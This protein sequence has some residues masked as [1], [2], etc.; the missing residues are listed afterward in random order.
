MVEGSFKDPFFLILDKYVLNSHTDTTSMRSREV[1]VRERVKQAATISNALHHDS[2]PRSRDRT[3]TEC[4]CIGLGSDKEASPPHCLTPPPSVESGRSNAAMDSYDPSDGPTA[5]MKSHVRRRP[6]P[7]GTAS[8][9]DALLPSHNEE[10]YPV[11]QSYMGRRRVSSY[12]TRPWYR[13]PQQLILLGILAWAGSVMYLSSLAHSILRTQKE[14]THSNMMGSSMMTNDEY[15]KRW[16]ESQGVSTS[17][18]YGA[19]ATTSDTSTINNE[20]FQKWLANQNK[21][22]ASSSSSSSDL[23]DAYQD[24]LQSLKYGASDP[25]TNNEDFKKWLAEQNK[26]GSGDKSTNEDF[27]KWLS[28]QNKYGSSSS[29]LGDAYQDYLQALKYGASDSSANEDFQKW[30][31]EQNKYGASNNDLGDAYQDW[32]QSLKYGA[33]SSIN[34]GKA[35]SVNVRFG[36]SDPS[37]QDW[38]E[39]QSKNTE[40]KYNANGMFSSDQPSL[41]RR[42]DSELSLLAPSESTSSTISTIDWPLQGISHSSCLNAN[43]CS[44][45]NNITVLIVYGPEFHSHISE[46]AWNVAIGVHTAFQSHIRHHPNSPT[47]GHIVYGHTSNITFSDVIDADAIIIGSPVYNGNVHPDVQNVSCI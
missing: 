39:Y 34:G 46:M 32:L 14:V 17:T 44:P 23:G 25:L 38:L 13:Q 4:V 27:Q 24:W 12:N 43:G 8:E 37:Y 22:G 11:L 18:K 28:N 33:S 10:G 5:T 1:S 41:N 31:A 26:Y 20:D 7:Y 36:N 42:P 9:D 19:S 35:S 21:Y 45:S 6:P 15:Y 29:N 47:H 40:V 16:L 3:S 30:L 2:R